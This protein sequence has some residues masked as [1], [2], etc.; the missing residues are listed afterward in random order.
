MCGDSE[1]DPG[2]LVLEARALDPAESVDAI[3]ATVEVVANYFEPSA[4]VRRAVGSVGRVAVVGLVQ[5]YGPDRGP[6]ATRLARKADNGVPVDL[7]SP[8]DPG[9][10]AAQVPREV[11]V[12]AVGGLDRDEDAVVFVR[13]VAAREGHRATPEGRVD[14][15]S[16]IE[17]VVYGELVVG[18][19]SP[20]TS[21]VLVSAVGVLI[22]VVG[23]ADDAPTCR[24]A[25]V[26]VSVGRGPVLRLE[27]EVGVSLPATFCDRSL[28]SQRRGREGRL[29]LRSRLVDR[30][31]APGARR[32]TRIVESLRR[33]SYR[34]PER[35]D[36]PRGGLEAQSG[37]QLLRV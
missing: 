27:E 33:I 12:L 21:T 9:S 34:Q 13:D 25:I 23:P 10:E 17:G 37:E 5:V 2:A 35:A 36:R 26:G 24:D 1:T 30:P 14:S 19:V 22:P 7:C 32:T 28:L 4:P 31:R 11:H 3:A 6:T 15:I 18:V 20:V 29:P 16:A 8:L